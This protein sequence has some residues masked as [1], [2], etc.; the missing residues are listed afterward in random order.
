[1]AQDPDVLGPAFLHTPH[2]SRTSERNEMTVGNQTMGLWLRGILGAGL[3]CVAAF[4]LALSLPA[5]GAETTP[6]SDPDTAAGAYFCLALSSLILAATAVVSR[7]WKTARAVC[8]LHLVLITI[9]W[10]QVPRPF[11]LGLSSGPVRQ[12]IT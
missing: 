11:Q 4:V 7:R 12:A 5:V 1:M 3:Y 8:L 10:V 6:T 2:V 9:I